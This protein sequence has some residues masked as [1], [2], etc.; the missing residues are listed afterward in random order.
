[1]SL[2]FM[3]QLMDCYKETFHFIYTRILKDETVRFMRFN[4]HNFD[5]KYSSF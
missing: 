5:L 1:M 3:L 4:F 2:N